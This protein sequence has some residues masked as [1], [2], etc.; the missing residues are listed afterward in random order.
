MLAEKSEQ[1]K[2]SEIWQ[3]EEV[4]GVKSFRTG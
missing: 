1:E 3:R 2:L 4:D